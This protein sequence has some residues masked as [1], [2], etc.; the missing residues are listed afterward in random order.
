MTQWVL[1]VTRMGIPSILS[2]WKWKY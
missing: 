2:W 1:G